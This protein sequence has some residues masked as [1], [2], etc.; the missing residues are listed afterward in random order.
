MKFSTSICLPLK[1]VG[2]SYLM[3][4]GY[5]WVVYYN[6]GYYKILGPASATGCYYYGYYTTYYDYG[7]W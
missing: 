4:N 7:I 5:Y 1:V 2:F 3:F 6:T